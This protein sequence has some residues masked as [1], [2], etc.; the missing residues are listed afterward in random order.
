M[1]MCDWTTTIGN[2]VQLIVRHMVNNGRQEPLTKQSSSR[3]VK[4]L[5]KLFNLV[6]A[7][8]YMGLGFG[9]SLLSTCHLIFHLK[10]Y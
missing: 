5:M 8:E 10:S 3:L 1:T 2:A 4:L 9:K 6:E 7:N